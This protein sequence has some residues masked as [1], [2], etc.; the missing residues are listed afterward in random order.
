MVSASEYRSTFFDVEGKA[1]IEQRRTLSISERRSYIDAVHCLRN[2]PT[3]YKEVVGAKSRFDDFQLVHIDQAYDIH[4]NVS[5]LI[6][7]QYF[8]KISLRASRLNLPPGIVGLCGNTN[9]LSFRN[10]AMEAR[11]RGFFHSF[12][13]LLKAIL[14]RTLQVLGL[15]P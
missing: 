2:K 8:G 5:S 6:Q 10:V 13:D 1:D 7:L 15:V 4:F 3:L 14:K 9:Q 12:V 11:N